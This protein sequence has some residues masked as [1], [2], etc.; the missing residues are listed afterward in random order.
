MNGY[1]WAASRYSWSENA[2]RAGDMLGGT[3]ERCQAVVVGSA[4]VAIGVILASPLSVFALG[5]FSLCTSP[6]NSSQFV[7]T[8][9]CLTVGTLVG[10]WTVNATV[11][12]IIGLLMATMYLVARRPIE[13]KKTEEEIVCPEVPFNMI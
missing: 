4:T 13:T 9:A 11:P 10:I 2:R 1:A 3:G 7:Q 12:A 6:T 5:C 8:I